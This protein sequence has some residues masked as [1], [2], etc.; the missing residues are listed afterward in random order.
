MRRR[1]LPFPNL[2]KADIYLGRGVY[3]KN[4]EKKVSFLVVFT[5]SDSWPSSLVSWLLPLP[6][7]HLEFLTTPHSHPRQ[8]PGA[9]GHL[10][11][12]CSLLL[13]VSCSHAFVQDPAGLSQEWRGHPTCFC[14]PAKGLMNINI[15]KHGVP[16]RA[17]EFYAKLWSSVSSFGALCSALGIVARFISSR[18]FSRDRVFSLPWEI[19][20]ML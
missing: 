5:A 10:F 12:Q 4:W 11:L 8:L 9:H 3:G 6:M 20:E 1:S 19:A 14:L 16:S 18:I 2:P 17:L 7:I 15:L 13:L